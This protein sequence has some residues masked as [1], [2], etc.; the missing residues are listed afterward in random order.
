VRVRYGCAAALLVV[1]GVPQ[2]ADAHAMLLR[3]SPPR[4]AVL[5]D[6]PKQVELWFNERLEPAYS[7]VTV[8]TQSGSRI[9]AAAATIGGQDSKRLSLTLPALAAGSYTVKFRVLSVDGHLAE[10]SFTFVVREN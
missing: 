9:N 3:T 6:P 7:T 5:R 2:I 8:S 10:D 1:L 4:R